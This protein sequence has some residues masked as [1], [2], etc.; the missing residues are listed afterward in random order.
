M[1]QK[2]MTAKIEKD[3]IKMVTVREFWGRYEPSQINTAMKD[4]VCRGHPQLA[5]KSLFEA[6]MD[7]AREDGHLPS[8]KCNTLVL[9]VGFSLE[10]LLQSV[11]AYKPSKVFLILNLEGYMGETWKVFADHVTEAIGHLVQ[12]GLLPMMPQFL[13]KNGEG[14]PTISKPEA[15][16]QTLVEALHDETNVV[17]DITGGKK[18]MVTG[19]YMYAAYAGTR[20]S[21]VDFEEYD[22]EHRRPYGYSCIIGELANPY[23]EFSLREWERVRAL[24]SRYQFCDARTLLDL[25]MPT[26]KKVMP[27]TEAPISKLALLLEYYRKWDSG[28]FRGAKQAASTLGEFK[29]Q[30]SAV[31]TLGDH[32][33]ETS[34]NDFKNKPVHFYGDSSALQ[35]YVCDELARIRRLIDYNEDY[36][37]AFLRAGS[38]NEIIMIAR[39]VKLVT[40]RDD[41]TKL[42]DSL[43]K[44]TPGASAVFDKLIEPTGKDIKIDKD[45]KKDTLSFPGAPTITIPHPAPMNFWWRATRLFNNHDG[46]KK[47]LY[48]RNDL[49]HQ[50]FSVPSQWA[51]EAHRFVQADFEDFLGHQI[52]DL[53]LRT[54]ILPWQEI[55][56]LCGITPF[57][58]TNLRKGG[59]P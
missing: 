45:R 48:R 57:L 41:Q 32:W 18:S 38:V 13:G 14:Y 9:L 55:C 15:V 28:D 10:P 2:D 53:N 6:E 52:S 59:E 39:L 20:I 8:D 22:P 36:R 47:F 30:P 54:S 16:F 56:D 12:K 46:W 3:D 19:A 7:C 43:D 17:I 26:M 35:A 5:G 44:K 49:A 51:E 42:L 40:N 58:P 50:Y 24:Y 33:F 4:Y 34:H 21:Y 11:Y 29:Q 31:T 27:K 1:A 25:I 37:S 23:R